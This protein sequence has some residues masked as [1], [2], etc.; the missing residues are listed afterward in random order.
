MQLLIFLTSDSIVIALTTAK[1][2]ELFLSPHW[3]LMMF[4]NI[5]Q[6]ASAIAMWG[7]YKRRIYRVS[8]CIKGY[9]KSNTTNTNHSTYSINLGNIIIYKKIS[10]QA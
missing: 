8:G 3:Q 7:G 1:Q 9:Y 4:R 10:R 2:V 6:C 5:D